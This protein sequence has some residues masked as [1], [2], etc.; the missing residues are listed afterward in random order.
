MRESAGF[1]QRHELIY[2]QPKGV[3]VLQ[4]GLTVMEKGPQ[5]VL[6]LDLCQP[7]MVLAAWIPWKLSQHGWKRPMRMLE[8]RSGRP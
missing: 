1:Y 5:V 8:Q 4:A 2:D 6:D 7:Q 3:L